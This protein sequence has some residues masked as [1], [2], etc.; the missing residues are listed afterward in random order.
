MSLRKLLTSFHFQ[1][2]KVGESTSLRDWLLGT[3]VAAVCLAPIGAASSLSGACATCCTS[4]T[5][6]Q[7]TNSAGQQCPYTDNN[8]LFMI[9]ACVVQ[10][11]S[12]GQVIL[13]TRMKCPTGCS[14]QGGYAGG[15]D[16]S[17]QSSCYY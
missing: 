7:C 9:E 8:G 2:G 12:G 17:Q 1:R 13:G 11:G 4:A 14:A 10:M 6:Q 15:D 5:M 16:C 3:G